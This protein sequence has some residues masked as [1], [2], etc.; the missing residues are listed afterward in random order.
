MEAE[1]AAT[2]ALNEIISHLMN[3]PPSV[4]RFLRAIIVERDA[5]RAEVAAIRRDFVL[6]P[7]VTIGKPTV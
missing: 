2:E 4:L 3:C 7:T 1:R 6:T 5:L